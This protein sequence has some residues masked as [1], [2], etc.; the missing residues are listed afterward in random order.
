LDGCTLPRLA[1]RHSLHLD[2]RWIG[3]YVGWMEPR[4][5][6]GPFFFANR[7]IMEDT[8]SATFAAARKSIALRVLEELG[9]VGGK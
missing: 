9:L 4:D 5:G 8:T 6:R 7:L 3:W 1:T 2:G